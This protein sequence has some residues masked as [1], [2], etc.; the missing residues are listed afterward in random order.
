MKRICILAVFVACAVFGAI[1]AWGA[2]TFSW[3]M[4]YA[5]AD[6]DVWGKW[7]VHNPSRY[8]NG[9]T[10]EETSGFLSPIGALEGLINHAANLDTTVNWVDF[11][12]P[13]YGTRFAYDLNGESSYI[14]GESSDDIIYTFLASNDST[15]NRMCNPVAVMNDM[16]KHSSEAMWINLNGTHPVDCFYAGRCSQNEVERQGTFTL[17]RHDIVPIRDCSDGVRINTILAALDSSP[18]IAQLPNSPSY[19][20]SAQFSACWPNGVYR[21]ARSVREAYWDVTATEIMDEFGNITIRLDSTYVGTTEVINYGASGGYRTLLITGYNLNQRYWICRDPLKGGMFGGTGVVKI[22]FNTGIGGEPNLGI[23]GAW[24]VHIDETS[25][26]KYVPNFMT[27]EKAAND[28]LR[29]NEPIEFGADSLS[30]PSDT[31]LPVRNSDI[32]NNA[33]LI[34]LNGHSIKYNNAA[35]GSFIHVSPDSF[36][37]GNGTYTGF[38]PSLKSMVSHA[39]AGDTLY[40]PAGVTTIAAG[41]TLS[42][43]DGVVVCMPQ[44]IW[45]YNYGYE[46]YVMSVPTKISVNGRLHVGSGAKFI[47]LSDTA[48]SGIWINSTGKMKVNGPCA[49]S[50]ATDGVVA[51]ANSNPIENTSETNRISITDC[52]TGVK[53]SSCAPHLDYFTITDCEYGVYV[54]SCTGGEIHN[55]TVTGA[56][57]G[58]WCYSCSGSV[59]IHNV[60]V[61]GIGSSYGIYLSKSTASL[62]ATITEATIKHFQMGIFLA[63]G[64][65]S[66]R[67]D[68]QIGHTE[69]DSCY[70][71]STS[72]VGVYT[73]AYANANVYFSEITFCDY[74]FKGVS[75]GSVS[76]D[77]PEDYGCGYNTIVPKDTTVTGC[78]M[79]G[80]AGGQTVMFNYW[81][82]TPQSAWF[83]PY[84]PDYSMWLTSPDASAGRQ[85]PNSNKTVAAQTEEET[86]EAAA[87]AAVTN[88]ISIAPN[89]ANP[90]TTI[91]YSLTK[92]DNVKLTVYSLNGQ[93]V[94]T[95]VNGPVTA[96]VHSATFNGAKF[97]SGIYFYRFESAG[98]KKT[99]K[100]MLLK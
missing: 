57:H 9:N 46:E 81:G 22:G 35:W 71:A 50:D 31:Y 37:L 66:V 62:Y 74:C 40:F 12:S 53:A 42:I 83:T 2:P 87:T 73:A 94:A 85:Y 75:V 26:P 88:A 30:L 84:S 70:T 32:Y 99:G 91:T 41:D 7:I 51:S 68:A 49:I 47:C 25:F 72:G 76:M 60:L 64:T 21:A 8:G 14:Y 56:T 11:Y 98:M 36:R 95:L 92:A 45:A 24:A 39:S 16:E 13:L 44:D 20:N 34:L 18:V 100:F 17:A 27:L 80:V 89:P 48:W 6:S 23:D 82:G 63:S 43:P 4:S 28:S 1:G 96:G 29:N 15:I 65:S 3:G 58:I 38:Y 78:V 93:K 79:Y 5:D 10:R 52:H 97:A 55:V 86:E 77:A 61:R 59:S 67:V 90:A 19:Q 69:I 33:P 54:S